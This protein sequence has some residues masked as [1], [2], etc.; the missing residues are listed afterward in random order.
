MKGL[1]FA[2]P[3]AIVYLPLVF[4]PLAYSLW[5]SLHFWDGLDPQW[6]WVGIRNYADMIAD[7]VFWRALAHNLVLV[8]FSLVVQLPIAM[9]LAV[10]LDR[11]TR[12]GGLLRTCIFLPY[13][14]PT[15]VIALVWRLLINAAFPEWL[16]STDWSLGAILL[17]VTWRFIGFHTVLYLA[18]LSM[19]DRQLHEAAHIDGANEWQRF[20][21][22]TLPLLKPVVIVSATLAV[23]GSMKYF[24]IVYL[25]TEGNPDHATELLATYLVSQA[26]DSY[27]MGYSSAIA[28]TLVVLAMCATVSLLMIRRRRTV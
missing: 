10:L 7:S 9:L 20:R 12:L 24:D 22:V 16:A 6:H 13:V 21:H 3:A 17:A 18:G 28:V 25:M 4:V 2:A 5:L 27:R 15:V 1:W 11:A 14:L 19:I 23:V 26:F 8:L